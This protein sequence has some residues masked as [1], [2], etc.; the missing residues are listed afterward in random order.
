[1]T[2][3]PKPSPS[4]TTLPLASRLRGVERTLIRQ[5]F[6]SAPPSA[7][8][9]GLGQPDLPSPDVIKTAAIDAITTDRAAFYLATAGDKDLRAAVAAR[10]AGFAMGPESVLITI[11]TGEAVFLACMAIVEP[12]DEVLIPDPGYPAYATTVRILGGV[13]VR[14]P[15]R[16][17]RGFRI[18]PKD[19]EARITPRTKLLIHNSPGNPTGALD[20]PEDLAR[21]G[22]M[23]EEGRIVW[24][25][26]EIYSA[27]AYERPFVS[28]SSLSKR[29]I[30]ASGLSKNISM[31]GW[32]LGWLVADPSFVTAATTLHQYVA[33]CSVTVSQRAALA[34]FT[35][36]G[37]T[38]ARAIVERFRHRRE[39][40]LEILAGA[41]LASIPRPD[42]AFYIYV[43]VS[44]KGDAMSVC[45]GLMERGVI[46]IP[47]IA[48]GETG[49]GWLRISYAAD[50][51]D[52]ERGLAI[53]RDYLS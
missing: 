18:D 16:P 2:Q 13:P 30:V 19:V 10:Y 17:E 40:A 31:A 29:G 38:A 21:I 12:G 24:L 5:I 32:R 7:I 41:R 14:F 42:G 37:E 4:G 6:D 39:R 51:K 20:M 11:G 46:T 48:F 53:V 27:F 50:E 45:R 15:L 36:A 35:P 22:A 44:R 34:A 28:L 43:D 25:T 3:P 1:M 23:A 33:T 8:N 9:F 49:E 26:D 52:L 47:G